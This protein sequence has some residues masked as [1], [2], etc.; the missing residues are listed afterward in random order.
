M[1]DSGGKSRVKETLQPLSGSV[2]P[3]TILARLRPPWLWGMLKM[4]L[5]VDPFQQ[6][7]L[8][9]RGSRKFLGQKI[10]GLRLANVDNLYISA[11]KV[12]DWLSE[13]P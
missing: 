12:N 1:L 2:R 13:L 11:Y 7:L 6:P 4:G 3:A 8:N 5:F 9:R 10:I